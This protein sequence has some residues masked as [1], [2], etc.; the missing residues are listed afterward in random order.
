MSGNWSASYSLELLKSLMSQDEIDMIWH[1]GDVGY[2]DDACFHTIA[3]ALQFE[4]EKAYNGYMNWISP[5]TTQLPYHV[6]VGNHEAECHDPLCILR[7]K[8]LGKP[9]SN[10]TAYN[11]RWAMP[12]KESGGV[13]NMWY[14][15]NYGPIHFI[16]IDTSTDFPDAPEQVKGGS[17]VFEAGYFAAD[18]E[19]MKWVENDLKAAAS[20][21]SIRWIIA[22][23]HRPF[24]DFNSDQLESLFEQYGVAFYFAGHSHSYSRFLSDQ[25]HGVTHVVVG[26]AGCEEMVFAETNPTPGYHT[27]ATCHEWS[28]RLVKGERRNRES[29]CAEAEFFTDAYAIGKLTAQDGGW[30]DLQWELLSSITGEVID[31]VTIPS[32]KFPKKKI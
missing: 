30:G 9:L 25:H 13:E 3:T 2:A 26:G 32:E 10:F 5:L 24:E 1:V 31:Y 23:G 28:T 18:G 7:Y 21:P 14:S 4:Y 19:Y 20:D 22:G 29:V 17:H 11:A 16:S 12:S 15:W 6:V 27:N 8:E